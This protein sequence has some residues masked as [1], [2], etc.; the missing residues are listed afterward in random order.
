MVYLNGD[1]YEPLK[2]IN[3][4]IK[5]NI[6]ELENVAQREPSS[7]KIVALWSQPTLV[8][9][10]VDSGLVFPSGNGT[11]T[12]SSPDTTGVGLLQGRV[13]GAD[14]KFVSSTFALEQ[15]NIAEAQTLASFIVNSERKYPAQNYALIFGD[16][17]GG[18]DGFNFDPNFAEN[19][20]TP[21]LTPQKLVTALTTAEDAG[22]QLSLL[23]FDECIMAT[24]EVE[25]EVRNLVS[26]V[27][28][29][30]ENSP[31]DGFN[32]KDGLAGVATE[33]PAELATS[34]V[35]SY[36]QK[37]K[38][39]PMTNLDD[40]LSAVRTD[41]L[42]TL[43]TDLRAFVASTNSASSVDWAGLRRANAYAAQF[44][45]S[46]YNYRDL[47]Q[48]LAFASRFVPSSTIR[49]AAST[50]LSAMEASVIAN[51]SIRRNTTGLSIV[52]P[53]AGATSPKPEVYSQQAPSFL[54][55]TG[56]SIFLRRLTT[57]GRGPVCP[58]PVDWAEFN[59]TSG[60]ATVLG[61]VYS[62][63]IS[64]PSLSLP[65]GD[66]DWFR[67]TTV[68]SGNPGD[69]ITLNSGLGN[70]DAQL[71]LFNASNPSVP[72]RRGNNRVILS[73]LTAG[74]YLVEV[75][76]TGNSVSFGYSL[77]INAPSPQNEFGNVP[78][79]NSVPTKAVELGT[80]LGPGLVTLP[81]TNPFNNNRPPVDL[82]TVLNREDPAVASWYRFET[83]PVITPLKGSIRVSGGT[84]RNLVVTLYDAQG[85]PLQTVEGQKVV[86]V[87][88]TVDGSAYYI[89]VEGGAGTY[90]LF[91]TSLS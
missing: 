72:I 18:I 38:S 54:A 47:G 69:A 27:V 53:V 20:N 75:R 76:H 66:I 61:P 24:A 51:T 32:Y 5:N 90:N 2:S 49:S 52:L 15:S 34:L 3:E 62:S 89:T 63:G 64:I 9:S 25:Y 84:A 43:A 45:G 91:F 36:E 31:G 86:Q 35:K 16:H 7:V 68:G 55:A 4:A 60:A 81:L 21:S 85:Q 83:P 78:N 58:Y 19:G 73:G 50:A 14:P 33:T 79:E 8:P 26:Y 28:A 30:Q 22:A 1:D 80:V 42:D 10:A 77:T 12:W 23:A 17:G 71:V 74:Q 56:W 87:P 6:I 13:S 57:V 40:T 41:R 67:F 88:Y 48:F 70:S 59:D 65:R 82:F 39:Q 29:S 46:G 44:G 37:Y 11:Q